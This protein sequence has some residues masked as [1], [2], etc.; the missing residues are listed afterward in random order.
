V[1][2]CLNYTTSYPEVYMICLNNTLSQT[3]HILMTTMLL[4]QVLKW[5]NNQFEENSLCSVIYKKTEA[6]VSIHLRYM[7]V[8]I[9]RDTC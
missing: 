6:H 3:Q 2:E 4:V 5:W 1:C 7:L 8:V 9:I